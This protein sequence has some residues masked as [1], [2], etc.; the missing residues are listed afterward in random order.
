MA[1]LNFNRVEKKY[2]M[3]EQQYKDLMKLLK[4]YI[5]LDEYPVSTTNTLYYDTPDFRIARYS[6][7]KTA[8]REKIRIR[9]YAQLPTNDS[10]SFIELKKK[11]DGIVY[12]RRI[13]TKVEKAL[14]YL[15][16]NFDSIE[17]TQIRRELDYF[18]KRMKT[19]KPSI[20]MYYDR[21]SYKDRETGEIRLTFDRNIVYRNY[22]LTLTEG[23]H[24]E[25]IIEPDE[26]LM[27]IKVPRPYP[28][29]LT[30]A[31]SQLKIYPHSFSKYKSAYELLREKG[32]ITY[33]G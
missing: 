24:G 25:R 6:Y 7:L 5:E 16:Y 12:K 3:K 23:N 30:D 4:D 22:V 18:L 20:Y 31:L 19:L 9:S 11:F 32:A 14:H 29:W 17:K 10:E 13:Y 28:L 21:N 2:L 1:L 8:F 33:N 27:K 15:D 26:V